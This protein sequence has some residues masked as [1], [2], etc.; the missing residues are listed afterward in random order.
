[1]EQWSL[2]FLTRDGCFVLPLLLSQDREKLAALARARAAKFSDE[3]FEE[4]FIDA[5]LGW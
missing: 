5:L 1:M 4:R 2:L 3:A